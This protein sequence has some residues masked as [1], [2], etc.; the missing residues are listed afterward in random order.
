MKKITILSFVFIAIFFASC[1]KDR[2]CTCTVIDNNPGATTSEYK[3]VY[4]KITKS[5]AKSAC[6]SIDIKPDGETTSTGQPLVETR[7]CKLN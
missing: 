1:K 4:K 3:V 6:M 5:N 7:K 2:A